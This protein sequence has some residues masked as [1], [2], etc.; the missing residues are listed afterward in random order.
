M[1]LRPQLWNLLAT[2]T[3]L[4]LLLL[5]ASCL[6]LDT[7][8]TFPLMCV[9]AAPW[10]AWQQEPVAASSPGTNWRKWMEIGA[11][12]VLVECAVCSLYCPLYANTDLYIS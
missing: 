1:S 9:S 8:V 10:L 3:P 11:G 6:S 4:V 5:Q 2:L 7:L 12:N